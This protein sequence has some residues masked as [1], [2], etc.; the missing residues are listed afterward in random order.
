MTEKKFVN[1]Y[2]KT[3]V[4]KTYATS[5]GWLE[6]TAEA[7]QKAFEKLVFGRKEQLEQRR[8]ERKGTSGTRLTRVVRHMMAIANLTAA[9][10][11]IKCLQDAVVEWDSLLKKGGAD[12]LV[13][14]ISSPRASA[15]IP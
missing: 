15:V 9:T 13:T 5:C 1:P 4:E 10:A 14:C 3:I 12:I 8:N 11:A 7:C 6:K 2:I